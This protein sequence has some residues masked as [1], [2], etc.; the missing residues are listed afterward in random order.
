MAVEAKEQ[1]KSYWSDEP[2]EVNNG[3]NTTQSQVL[4]GILL[5]DYERDRDLKPGEAILV[6]E[7]GTTKRVKEKSLYRKEIDNARQSPK[8]QRP[9]LFR[10]RATREVKHRAAKPRQTSQRKR[11]PIYQA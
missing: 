9:S 4:M 7:D 6:F 3:F 5:F 8:I 11:I 2:G 10:S 1:T